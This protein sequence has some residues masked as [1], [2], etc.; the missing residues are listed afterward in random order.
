M[1][2]LDYD[3][4]SPGGQHSSGAGYRPVCSCGLWK[5]EGIVRDPLNP[6]DRREAEAG[7][8]QHVLL[9]DD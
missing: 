3:A 8:Q 7:Y 2:R 9:A 5:F 4:I 1:H 6:Q